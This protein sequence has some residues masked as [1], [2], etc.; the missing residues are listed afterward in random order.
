MFTPLKSLG[1]RQRMEK[2]SERFNINQYL[3]RAQSPN[4]DCTQEVNLPS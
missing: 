1:L 4:L 2:G 3:H